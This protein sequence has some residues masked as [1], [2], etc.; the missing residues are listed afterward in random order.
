ME[1]EPLLWADCVLGAINQH[2]QL[3]EHTLYQ[4]QEAWKRDA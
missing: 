1:Q 4:E 3:L 2:S